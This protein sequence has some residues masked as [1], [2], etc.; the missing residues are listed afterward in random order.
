MEARPVRVPIV[1]NPVAVA[2]GSAH[3][4]AIRQGGATLC[5]GANGAGQLGDGSTRTLPIPVRVD[6]LGAATDVVAGGA[7]TCARG[8]GDGVFC[9]GDDR[10]GQLAIA[11]TTSRPRAAPVASLAGAVDLATGG[12]HGCAVLKGAPQAVTC[13]GANQAGQLGDGTTT[14]R[15]TAREVKGLEATSVGA[16]AAHTCATVEGGALWCW[17]RGGSGQLGRTRA[18]D[19]PSPAMVPLD[20]AARVAG[21]ALGE[22]HTCATL[23]DGTARCWGANGEGQLGDGTLVSQPLAGA[24]PRVGGPTPLL[25]IATLAAGDAHTC[26]RLAD[27]QVRCWG[28]GTR[29]QLGWGSAASSSVPVTASLTSGA[30]ALAA[31]AAHACAAIDDGLACWGANG[32]GQLG[33]APGADV[34]A[35]QP[36]TGLASARGVA[37]GAAHSCAVTDGRTV[38]CWG[39]ND[40][41]QLGDG[42]T[43]SSAAPVAVA[44]LTDVEQLSAGTAYTCARRTDGSVWCWGD[45]D[46]GQLGDDA[47]LASSTPRLARLACR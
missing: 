20:P 4:C 42:T 28:R 25:A 19:T 6:G 9:W 16:G 14:D 45:N 22:A 37:A 13:W 23:D 24:A 7:F 31:G 46:A 15:A 21:V 17:G 27:G 10:Y 41:G 2:A 36:V 38:V 11:R 44:G 30:H 39:D 18:V 33:A 1:T 47:P 29:G 12:A 8:G 40:D 43:T 32:E 3:T 26:A 35:P 34:T 5:W